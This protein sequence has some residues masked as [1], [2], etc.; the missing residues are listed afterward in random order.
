MRWSY[1]FF[2]LGVSLLTVDLELWES[3][4]CCWGI[5]L[6]GMMSGFLEPFHSYHTA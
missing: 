1:F 6:F 3:K 2:S 4:S 5:S